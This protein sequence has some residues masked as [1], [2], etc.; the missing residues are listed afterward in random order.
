MTGAAAQRLCI[1]RGHV[2]AHRRTSRDDRERYI[3]RDPIRAPPRNWTPHPE[4]R[5]NRA[6][7]IPV[8]IDFGFAGDLGA[9]PIGAAEFNP[10]CGQ[11]GI[12][13]MKFVQGATVEAFAEPSGGRLQ[14]KNLFV[15]LA[16]VSWYGYCFSR[17]RPCIQF[18]L[19]CC[20]FVVHREIPKN[21]RARLIQTLAVSVLC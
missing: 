9:D 5:F 16:S 17:S 12:F 1:G 6:A 20:L 13:T 11:T 18:A 4:V 21:S 15:L 10:E 19:A 8:N 3:A 2:E 7:P 14:A